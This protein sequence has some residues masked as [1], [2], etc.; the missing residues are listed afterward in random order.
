M[1]LLITVDLMINWL[2]D[3]HDRNIIH[4]DI[5]PENFLFKETNIQ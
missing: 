4:R 2:R 1:T 3:I 5:K